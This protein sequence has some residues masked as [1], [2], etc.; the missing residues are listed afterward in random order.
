[1]RRH[2]MSIAG[3][4]QLDPLGPHTQPWEMALEAEK[5]KTGLDPAVVVN[6][7]RRAVALTGN[8][9]FW[10]VLDRREG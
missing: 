1:M 10:A 9:S 6:L 4:I 3:R 5:S 7:V 2:Q 8:A